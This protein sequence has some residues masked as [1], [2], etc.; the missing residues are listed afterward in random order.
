MNRTKVGKLTKT[1]KEVILSRI[2]QLFEIQHEILFA[3]FHGSFL[4]EG[5]FNDIDIAVYLKE[6]PESPLQYE[7]EMEA[8]LMSSLGMFIIDVRVLN[9]SPLSFRYHV[10]KDGRLLMVR[11]DDVRAEFQENTIK[12]YLDFAPFR[13]MY[14][15]EVLGLGI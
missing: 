10:I 15:R 7:L 12:H 9:G 5:N 6:T 2:T 14:L 1:E 4:Q 13:K 8:A 3:Y 11:D